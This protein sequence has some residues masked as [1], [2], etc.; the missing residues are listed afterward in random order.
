MMIMEEGTMVVEI[1]EA[2]KRFVAT[3][4]FVLV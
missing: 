2:I 3:K 1:T 4:C